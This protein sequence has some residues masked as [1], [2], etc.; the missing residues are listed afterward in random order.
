MSLLARLASGH[1][2]EDQRRI[3]SQVRWIKRVL[4]AINLAEG[5]NF[6]LQSR[7]IKGRK[8]PEIVLVGG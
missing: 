1:A 7:W 2:I 3:T 6:S 8:L 5:S 4:Q